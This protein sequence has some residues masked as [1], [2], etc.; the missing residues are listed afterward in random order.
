MTFDQFDIDR[1]E[2]ALPDV[3]SGWFTRERIKRA[4]E[5]ATS[6]GPKG[7]EK[8]KFIDTEVA[9]QM[10]GKTLPECLEHYGQQTL[11]MGGPIESGYIRY[12]CRF[13]PKFFTYHG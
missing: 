2:R 11:V 5:D 13:F 12:I 10:S 4:F 1:F 3:A 9:R 6:V 8:V 7:N